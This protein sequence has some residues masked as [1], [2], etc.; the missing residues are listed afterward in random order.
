MREKIANSSKFAVCICFNPT[1]ARG[2][3]SMRPAPPPLR[4]RLGKRNRV[5]MHVHSP[6]FQGQLI[7]N[8]KL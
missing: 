7:E 6:I 1:K 4:K 2:S 5:E 3:E 8:K